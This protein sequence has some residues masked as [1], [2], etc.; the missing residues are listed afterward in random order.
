MVGS[1]A[2]VQGFEE[3][4]HS[5]TVVEFKTFGSAVIS[6]QDILFCGNEE[7][8]FPDRR[9]RAVIYRISPTRLYQGVGCHDLLRVLLIKEDQ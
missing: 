1:P 3:N 8:S 2:G 4:G 6:S 5:Y 9:L 7:D